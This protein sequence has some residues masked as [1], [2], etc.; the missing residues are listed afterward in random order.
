MTPAFPRTALKTVLPTAL[1]VLSLT[2]TPLLTPAG[3]QDVTQVPVTVPLSVEQERQVERIGM[4]IH[5]PICSGESIAQSQTDISRQMMNEVRAMV[6]AGRPE[7]EILNTF[8]ASYGDRILLE[9]P[10]TG[11]NSLLWTLPVAFFV[12]GGLLWWNYTQRASRPVQ[13][14]LTPEEEQRIQDLMADR[15]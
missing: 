12:L 7:Q 5:C 10:K 14:T 4:K 1:T 6:K 15:E 13:R 3:A 9:P 8:A 11:V 2:L